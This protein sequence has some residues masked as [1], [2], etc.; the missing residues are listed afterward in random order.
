MKVAWCPLRRGIF[1]IERAW[2][3]VVAAMGYIRCGV[4]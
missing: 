4:A 1:P 3:R 2:V